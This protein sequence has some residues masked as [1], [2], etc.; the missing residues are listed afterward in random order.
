MSKSKYTIL[1]LLL[2]W[3]MLPS[4][5]A[6]ESWK[7]ILSAVGQKYRSDTLIL[8][9]SYSEKKTREGSFVESAEGYMVLAGVQRHVLFPEYETLV[10]SEY[11]IKVD[12]VNK[13]VLLLK[14]TEPQDAAGLTS[15][16]EFSEAMLENY[17]LAFN[18]SESQLEEG[19]LVFSA[20]HSEAPYRQWIIHCDP[21]TKSMRS[22]TIN[23]HS[24]FVAGL[25]ALRIDFKELSKLPL[26]SKPLSIENYLTKETG[27]EELLEKY[28]TYSLKKNF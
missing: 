21:L 25:R 6:Q 16:W 10:N 22:Y 18:Q 12:H 7:D 20:T 3:G 19:Y 9:L 26:E 24:D 2:C 23:Y 17:A 28:K 5:R 27:Q 13:E 1:I 11:Y 4:L 8:Q 14:N 15:P